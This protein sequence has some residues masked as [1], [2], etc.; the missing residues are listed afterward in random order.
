MP[1]TPPETN[2]N[3]Q[4]PI[5]Q[6]P[7][8][9]EQ[10]YAQQD[11]FY[12]PEDIQDEGME[13][14]QPRPKVSGAIKLLLSVLIIAGALFLL[15]SFVFTIKNIHFTGLKN[16]SQADAARLTRLNSGLFYFTLSEDFVQDRVESNY[17]FIYEGMA[18]IFPNGLSVKVIERYPF[19]F[20][21]HLGVGYVLAQDGF[22]LR[23]TR[24]LKEGLQLIQVNG[25][26]VWG[27]QTAGSFPTSTDPSQKDSMIALF[28]ELENWGFKTEIA[29]I[30][31]SQTLNISLQTKD[32]YTINLG[33]EENL[34]AKIGTVA[35]VVNELRRRNMTGGIIEAT[36]PGE[37]TYRIEQ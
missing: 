17:Y 27:Q 36:L 20:F 11:P 4:Q 22:I 14:V 12:Q 37:A 18:K 19:A 6:Q 32:G 26:A 25:L 28:A 29:T 23:E 15:K 5:Q 1:P 21:T 2:R 35:S 30:D 13:E 3:K 24:D 33:S 16:I 7:W 9:D 8:V 31:M 10:A 34:H